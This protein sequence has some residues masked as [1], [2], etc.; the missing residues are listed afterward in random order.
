MFKTWKLKRIA[1]RFK[2]RN[3]FAGTESRP[4][5]LFF[6]WGSPLSVDFICFGFA[7]SFF[8]S[9]LYVNA[10]KSQ[11]LNYNKNNKSAVCIKID[12]HITQI[13]GCNRRLH[14][15]AR[16]HNPRCTSPARRPAPAV[17][18][19]QR[20]WPRWGRWC[21]GGS[22]HLKSPRR[23]PPCPTIREWGR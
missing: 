11:P 16:R 10:V 1:E 7:L 14:S 23:Y 20:L 8:L 15:P 12:V 19:Q 13:N 22:V 4:L 17:Y 3:L 21:W 2:P 9:L 6:H 18:R 5:K